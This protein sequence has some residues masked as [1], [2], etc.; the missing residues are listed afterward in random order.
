M[1]IYIRLL[2]HLYDEYG[3]VQDDDDDH[4]SHNIQGS[5]DLRTS[6]R[7][8]SSTMMGPGSVNRP[9]IHARTHGLCVRKYYTTNL[10]GLEATPMMVLTIGP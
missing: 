10:F 6:P 1:Y 4:V 8:A 5:V 7:T 9:G 3:P 2:P